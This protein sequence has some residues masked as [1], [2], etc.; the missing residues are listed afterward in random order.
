[1]ATPEYNA[2]DDASVRIAIPTIETEGRDVNIVGC[3]STDYVI[4]MI[5]PDLHQN[6][7]HEFQV[8]FN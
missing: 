2:T 4:A 5:S 3:A 8:S 7:P 1:M 6:V